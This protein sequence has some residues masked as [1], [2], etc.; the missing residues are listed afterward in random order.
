MRVIDSEGKQPMP[1]IVDDFADIRAQ[2]SALSD[3]VVALV[4]KRFRLEAQGDTKTAGLGPDET[5]AVT[6]ETAREIGRLD[7]QIAS[8]VATSAAG[9]IRQVRV[10]REISEGV[11]YADNDDHR[12]DG[13]ADRLEA[14][15]TA[16]I[17]RLAGMR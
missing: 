13:C 14:S 7:D 9:I 5:H 16:G 17:E 3:P 6:V 10:L 12:S 11:Y 8:I 15:I 1:N 4:A 2:L